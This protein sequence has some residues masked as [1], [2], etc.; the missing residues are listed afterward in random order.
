MWKILSILTL[1]EW[2]NYHH[3]LYFWFVAKEGS[4][5]RAC[6]KLSL[7][8]PT[9]SAQIHEL[10]NALGEKLFTRIGRN[11]VLT[12]VGRVVF[13]YADEIFSLG[14]ELIDT[15]KGRPT[16]LPIRFMVGVAD[17]LP[18]LI[19]QRL[20]QPVLQLADP[21]RLVCKEGKSDRLLADL[22]VHELDL[23]LTDTPIAPTVKV[24]AF[25][26]LLGECGVSIFG[27]EEL[28]GNYRRGFPKSLN[29]APFIM[30]TE[31][32]ALRRSLDQWFENDGIHPHIVGEFEDSALLKVF[33]Q[34]GL[35]LFAG[36]SVIEKEVE[37]QYKVMVI[38]RVERVRERFYAISVERKLK[39]P[40]IIA[41]SEA[42][43]EKLF[44]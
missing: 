26:H 21:I 4:L 18:K 33:G 11:L 24:R 41:I 35:G 2:L 17:V 16:G 29:N 12:D 30:P 28:A 13:R 44:I 39:H 8:Q 20:L 34:T 27:V 25:N 38:G 43:R 10:E 7:T 14:R 23:V 22:A 9:I 19:A 15:I 1:M 36:H 5:A 3:L 31:N 37:Q 40:A 32:T 6:E 42:A